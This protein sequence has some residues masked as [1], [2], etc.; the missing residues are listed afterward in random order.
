MQLLPLGAA[1]R[2][3]EILLSSRAGARQFVEERPAAPA[4]RNRVAA[5]VAG[6]GAA[7]QKAAPLQLV[8]NGD[9]ISWVDPGCVRQPPLRSGLKLAQNH[10]DA[11]LGES[12]VVLV[13]CLHKSASGFRA[14]PRQQ[15]AGARQQSERLSGHP[16]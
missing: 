13:Q 3:Q 8:E 1:Q 16:T 14:S 9:Q 7:A 4:E 5:A 10:E 11:V 12:D 6:I 2:T 15:V